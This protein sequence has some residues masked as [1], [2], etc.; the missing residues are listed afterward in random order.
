[1]SFILSYFILL[2]PFWYFLPPEHRITMVLP[3]YNY[4]LSVCQAVCYALEIEKAR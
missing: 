3:K 2:H 4:V 1:M